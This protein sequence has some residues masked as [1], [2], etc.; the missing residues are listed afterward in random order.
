MEPTGDRVYVLPAALQPVQSRLFSIIVLLLR[1]ATTETAVE[2]AE[3]VVPCAAV[4]LQET[5]AWLGSDPS[6]G[7]DFQ[8]RSVRHQHRHQHLLNCP[9]A[10]LAVVMR[11]QCTG[12][13]F[14]PTRRP[15]LS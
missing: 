6:R 11:L 3:V 12:P 2:A 10:P 5:V 13:Y 8:L 7:L 1:M 15:S 9:L 4:V 14:Q